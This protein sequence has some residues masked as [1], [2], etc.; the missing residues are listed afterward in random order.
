MVKKMRDG[1]GTQISDE[2]RG[3]A[4]DRA[5]VNEGVAKDYREAKGITNKPFAKVTELVVNAVQKLKG[6][7]PDGDKPRD[8]YQTIRDF[9]GKMSKDAKQKAA[10]NKAVSVAMDSKY[11]GKINPPKEPDMGVAKAGMSRMSRPTGPDRK[12][13]AYNRRRSASEGRTVSKMSMGGK[14]RGMGAATKGG[15]FSKNG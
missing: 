8:R 14:A 11:E 7:S 2:K 4:Y 5:R 9:K 6:D 10:T 3:R 15:S 13:M 12:E 1:G